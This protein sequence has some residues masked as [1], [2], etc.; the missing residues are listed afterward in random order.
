MPEKAHRCPTKSNARAQHWTNNNKPTRAY[1]PSSTMQAHFFFAVFT[2]THL[3][4]PPPTCAVLFAPP[5]TYV[6]LFAPPPTY[7]VLFRGTFHHRVSPSETFQ[8]APTT[9]IREYPT[10]SSG[11]S[12]TSNE[13]RN[14][15]ATMPTNSRCPKDNSLSRQSGVRS[16]TRTTHTI[17]E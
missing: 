10:L 16:I 13:H 7:V 3:F 11:S 8:R 1:A 14:I 15:Q 6:V 12:E 17:F 4:A 9:C 5:P 2:T